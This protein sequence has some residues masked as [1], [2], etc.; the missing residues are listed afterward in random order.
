VSDFAVAFL[1]PQTALRG[2]GA[3]AGDT[4]GWSSLA[5]SCSSMQCTDG[6]PRLAFSSSL[7]RQTS[8][9]TPHKPSLSTPSSP[10]HSRSRPAG[11]VQY[12]DT[13]P[14]LDLPNSRAR[15]SNLE[16]CESTAHVDV[17]DCRWVVDLS[18]GFIIQTHS[19]GLQGKC[20][21]TNGTIMV[22]LQL[23]TSFTAF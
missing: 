6:W 18:Q 7:W 5:G 22:V 15:T 9:H 16:M 8:N 23:F 13:F 17:R 2:C 10:S 20:H 21:S 12:F 19:L 1:R 4:C 14:I 11:R 3:D